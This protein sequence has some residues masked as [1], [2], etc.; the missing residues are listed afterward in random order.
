MH[1][2]ALRRAP[3]VRAFSLAGVFVINLDRRP[4][5]WAAVSHLCKRAAL[6]PDLIE[7]VPAVEGSEVHV[8]ACY[9]CGVV[10][11]LGL[12]RLREPPAHHIWGMDLNPGALGCALSHIQLWSRIAASSIPS[13]ATATLS[14]PSAASPAKTCYL[15]LEDDAELVDSETVSSSSSPPLL[16]ELHRRMERR[17]PPD[18]ELVYI[19]GL[20]TAGQ[21]ASL[22]VA[23]GVARVPQYHRT[24]SA[25]LVT[26]LGARRLLATCLP[27]TFQLDTAMTMRVGLPHGSLPL[28]GALPYVLD[29]VSYT[30]QPPLLR[31]SAHLGTDIQ[32]RTA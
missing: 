17:V 31:Q 32:Q 15:V 25:Y 18:W 23:E 3:G 14:T 9:R 28:P 12:Q 8:E 1:R 30:L 29:P 22:A 10:S 20:D 21:C 5:R 11:R 16:E 13:V 27:L 26:P 4:D 19:G 24:T 2:T 7:R 6:P